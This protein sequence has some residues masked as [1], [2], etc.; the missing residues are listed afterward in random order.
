[1]LMVDLFS[2]GAALMEAEFVEG[3]FLGNKVQGIYDRI[4][5]SRGVE[6]SRLARQ[7]K[8]HGPAGE[9]L[10]KIRAEGRGGSAAVMGG[11]IHGWLQLEGRRGYAKGRR[12]SNTLGS[13]TIGAEPRLNR[14]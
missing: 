4:N 8:W 9:E 5:G 6:K 11:E 1:M 2:C 3:Q 13:G 12:Y 10:R 14:G 7:P